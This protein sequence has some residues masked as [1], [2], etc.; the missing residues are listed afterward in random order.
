MGKFIEKFCVKHQFYMVAG[1][2]S[3]GIISMLLLGYY[4][5]DSQIGTAGA[6]TAMTAFAVIAIVVIAGFAHYLGVFNGERAEVVVGA[7]N[8]MAQGDLT[9]KIDIRGKDEYAW[10]CWEY[11]CSRKGFKEM[12]EN[13]IANSAQLASAAEELSTITVQSSEGVSRQQNETQQVA[14]AMNEMSATVHEVAKNAAKAATAAHDADEQAKDGYKVVSKTVDTIN[15]LA[16]EVKRSSQVIEGVK[17]DTLSIGSVL[18]VIR[19]I[20]EQT[21]LLALNA[22]IEAARA[23]EQGRGFAVVA[24]EVRTLASRTQVST[25][26][27]QEMIERL[28]S[29]A[30]QAVDAMEKGR[31]K[32]AESVEQA[33]K[34]GA[35]LEAI[36]QMV[37]TITSMN[38][39]IAS[40]ANEQSTTAEEINRNI[41]NISQVADETAN[42]AQQTSRATN[43]LARLAVDLQQQVGRFQVQ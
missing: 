24:D 23:G 2:A 43:E 14:T 37:D 12:I 28:Q 5:F 41:V 9:K 20:A 25:Q 40:A 11:T 31:E 32:A 18:D 4:L 29:G 26:E 19:G 42:G 13:V 21:N 30:N 36:T 22:A 39:Q 35:A 8:K 27:I 33:G 17:N 34:A 10:M 1:I 15:D 6:M 16:A 38:T 7:M 3:A